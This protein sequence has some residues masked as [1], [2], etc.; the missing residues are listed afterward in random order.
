M[1]SKQQMDKPIREVATPHVPADHLCRR[2]TPVRDVAAVTCSYGPIGS[3][4]RFDDSAL[5]LHRPTRRCEEVVVRHANRS[6][7]RDLHTDDEIF[8]AVHNNELLY[9]Y[10]PIVEMRTGWLKSCEALLRWQHPRRGVLPPSQFLEAMEQGGLLPKIGWSLLP[11]AMSCLQTWRDSSESHDALTMNINLTSEQLLEPGLVQRLRTELT[12]HQLSP[13]ALRIEITESTTIS[14]ETKLVDTLEQ[15]ADLGVEIQLDDFGTGFASLRH[16]NELPISALKIDRS[17]VASLPNGRRQIVMVRSLIELSHD[18][19]LKVIAEGVESND[20][21]DL[22][23]SFG[24]DFAQGFLFDKP[25]D[26]AAFRSG[27]NRATARRN[28]S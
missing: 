28:G 14:A 1:T 2:Q 7:T 5:F 9:H 21:F 27:M 23:A 16:L 11:T 26:A 8:E 18:L 15:I 4:A 25:L 22:L 3:S 19:G 24:C 20:Q 10:Q 6:A 17:F 13:S 12:R